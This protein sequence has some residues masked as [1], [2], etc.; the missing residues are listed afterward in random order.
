MIASRGCIGTTS[1]DHM[2]TWFQICRKVHG[3]CAG[4]LSVQLST[5]SILCNSSIFAPET[6]VTTKHA[7]RWRSMMNAGKG[8]SIESSHNE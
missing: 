5:K 8:K 1:N 3:M 7:K 2:S 4:E 6:K